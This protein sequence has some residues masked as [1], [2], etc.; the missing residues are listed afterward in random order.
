MPSTPSDLFGDHH[1]IINFLTTLLNL[2]T[3]L[4][5]L[6]CP[7]PFQSKM[8]AFGKKR[9]S[10]SAI[11]DLTGDDDDMSPKRQRVPSPPPSPPVPP[12]LLVTRPPPTRVTLADLDVVTAPKTLTRQQ[13]GTLCLYTNFWQ[14]LVKSGNFTPE[15][16]QSMQTMGI[17]YL[18]VPPMADAI[19][20]GTALQYFNDRHPDR[21]SEYSIIK[22][23][24]SDTN[25]RNFS[26]FR[27]EE[28]LAEALAT[29][30]AELQTA[31]RIEPAVQ[32]SVFFAEHS[33]TPRHDTPPLYRDLFDVYATYSGKVLRAPSGETQLV[34]PK[35]SGSCAKVRGITTKL[36]DDMPQ[37]LRVLAFRTRSALGGHGQRALRRSNTHALMAVVH[38]PTLTDFVA[39]DVSRKTPRLGRAWIE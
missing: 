26:N 18:P 27:M 8:L 25:A 13:T 31:D 15:C 29:H 37:R 2:S 24:D 5:V 34:L 32:E 30:C 39:Y 19:S 3:D 21:V 36:V 12:R 10:P 20:V 23:A 28:V 16:L 6:V 7:S 14:Y 33:S 9:A 1:H 11:I 4:V 35:R 38:W 22:L 17:L